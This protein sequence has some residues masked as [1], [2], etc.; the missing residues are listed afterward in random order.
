MR[1]SIVLVLALTACG[2]QVDKGSSGGEISDPPAPTPGSTSS[3]TP[4][5]APTQTST[6]PGN[7]TPAATLPPTSLSAA[8]ACADRSQDDFKISSEGAP[9]CQ[10][11]NRVTRADGSSDIELVTG[12]AGVASLV[13]GSLM[14][15][16]GTDGKLLFQAVL[17]CYSTGGD[18]AIAP[19]DLILGAEASDRKCKLAISDDGVHV[20]GFIS[21]A[22]DTGA[23]D[24]FSSNSA[25]V[26]LGAFAVPRTF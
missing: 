17:R 18:Y 10:V 20:G 21:C 22:D 25:P 23:S 15:T 7:D 6:S 9:T 12:D 24:L 1:R 11:K 8:G 2:G 19:G 26:A 14:L 3:P 13:D 16:C 5:P 4:T